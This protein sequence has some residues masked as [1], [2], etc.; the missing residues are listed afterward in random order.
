M[1]QAADRRLEQSVECRQRDLEHEN[2]MLSNQNQFRSPL[3]LLLE[4]SSSL[5]Q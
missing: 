5:A 2:E 4:K 3:A 1:T